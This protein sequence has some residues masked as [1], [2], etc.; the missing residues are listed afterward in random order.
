MLRTACV[1]D[2]E[3]IVMVFVEP[4]TLVYSFVALRV[5][6]PATARAVKAGCLRIRFV[7]GFDMENMDNANL[8]NSDIYSPSL[9]LRDHDPFSHRSLLPRG[10]A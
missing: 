9:L 2:D 7:L 8:F 4:W 5:S 1:F 3:H 10:I 6:R